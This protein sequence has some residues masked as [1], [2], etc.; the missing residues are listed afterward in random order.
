MMYK[1]VLWM[2]LKSHYISTYLQ[3]KNLSEFRR[4]VA[5]GINY[6]LKTYFV[7]LCTLQHLQGNI[8]HWGNSECEESSSKILK[9]FFHVQITQ[10]MLRFSDTFADCVTTHASLLLCLQLRF[11]YNDVILYCIV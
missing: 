2:T 7:A 3:I 8:S 5:L 1:H 11:P 4:L 10:L 9:A 6:F